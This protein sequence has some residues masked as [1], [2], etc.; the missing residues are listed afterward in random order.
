MG[1]CDCLGIHYVDGE[2]PGHQ[3]CGANPETQLNQKAKLDK[4]GLLAMIWGNEIR[5][6]EFFRTQMPRDYFAVISKGYLPS[7]A[8]GLRLSPHLLFLLNVIIL[9]VVSGFEYLSPNAME[10]PSC[11][12]A[13]AVQACQISMS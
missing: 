9:P 4:L 1:D 11:G 12:G 5:A 10:A 3:M 8:I 7:G 2:S 6:Y 13:D